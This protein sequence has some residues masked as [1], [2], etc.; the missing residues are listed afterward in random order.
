MTTPTEVSRGME[1][2]I[3]ILFT[4]ASV[5][6]GLALTLPTIQLIISIAG[7]RV[8]VDL[9]TTA[10]LPFDATSGGA[11]ILSASY[12][13][14][15]VVATGLSGGVSALFIAAAVASALTTFLTVG[16]VVLFLLLLLWQ[17]PFHRALIAATLVA[18]TALLI[19]HLLA[20][21]LG[22]LG[23]MMAADELNPL[24]DDVFVVGFSFDPAPLLAG[25]SVLALSFVFSYGT[26]LQRDTK[27]LV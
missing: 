4:A 6:I 16:A 8:P 18:G 7:G 3:L 13:T 2:G 9:L 10:D 26:E 24:A 12:E 21:G 20:G 19:G 17:R 11:T 25:I 14:A 27:G 22:G 1:R 15:F 5:V 23:R